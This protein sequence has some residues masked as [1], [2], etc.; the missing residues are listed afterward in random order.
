[1]GIRAALGASP[2]SL[3]TLIVREGIRLTAAGLAIGLAG[4]FGATR[5]LSWMLFGV[6]AFDP[7]TITVVAVVLTGVAGLASY[8]PARRITRIDPMKVLRS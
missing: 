1:M 2:G 4:M 7:L 5:L 3:R 8:M 6:N